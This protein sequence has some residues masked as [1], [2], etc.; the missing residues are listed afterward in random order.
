M[1][2]IY[3]ETSIHGYNDASYATAEEL[4]EMLKVY[5]YDGLAAGIRCDA[6]KEKD[7]VMNGNTYIY[8]G[9][10]YLTGDINKGTFTSAGVWTQKKK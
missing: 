10:L 2:V 5:R 4:D 1:G 6:I 9:I 3:W 7:I 8:G